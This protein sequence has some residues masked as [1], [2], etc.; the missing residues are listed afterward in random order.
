MGRH[1]AEGI[2]PPSMTAALAFVGGYVDGVGFVGLFGLLTAHITGNLVLIG[3][4]VARPTHGVLLKVLALPAFVAAVAV[5]TIAASAANR[6]GRCGAALLLGLQA[7]LL[8]GFMGWGSLAV[9]LDDASA[10]ATLVAG[11]LGAAAMGMQAAAGKLFW[12]TVTPTS[13]MT[14]NITQLIIDVVEA[15]R[16][17][18]SAGSGGSGAALRAQIHGIVW[19]VAA[20]AAGAVAGPLAFVHVSFAALWLPIAILLALVWRLSC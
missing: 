15:A 6:A 12:P 8:L 17:G 1:D 13:T 11:M 20:F 5:A 19:P 2:E 10:V 16:S 18:G 3:S 4:E 9:P 7:V 14:G